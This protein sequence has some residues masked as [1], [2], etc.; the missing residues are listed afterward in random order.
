MSYRDLLGSL[1][2]LLTRGNLM[3][4]MQYVGAVIPISACVADTHDDVF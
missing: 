3:N 4:C 1:R 2:L